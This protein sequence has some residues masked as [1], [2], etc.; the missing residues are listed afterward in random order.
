MIHDAH[1]NGFPLAASIATTVAQRGAE[2]RED[3][4][5]NQDSFQCVNHVFP[6]SNDC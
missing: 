3:D 5:T 4:V 6:T 1:S 2:Y